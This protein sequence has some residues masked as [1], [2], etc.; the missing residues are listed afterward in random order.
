MGD[1]IKKAE[2]MRIAFGKA[3][4]V[5]NTYATTQ[6]ISQMAA[7]IKDP[8]RQ[9]FGIDPYK[10]EDNETKEKDT[11]TYRRRTLG[12]GVRGENQISSRAPKTDNGGGASKKTSGSRRSRRN[13]KRNGKTANV[14]NNGKRRKLGQGPV[15]WFGKSKSIKDYF[16]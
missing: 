15:S 4:R 9:V 11:K 8:S 12:E 1:S 13:S 14:L 16:E 7:H 3:R 2:D 5:E 6:W 10:L